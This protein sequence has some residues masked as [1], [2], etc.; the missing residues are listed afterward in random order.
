MN[1][2]DSF[3]KW[4]REKQGLSEK[5]AKDVLSRLNRVKKYIKLAKQLPSEEII[6]KMGQ[7]QEFKRLSMTVRSQLR[8]AIRLAKKFEKYK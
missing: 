6:F 4:L 7:N 2:G 5:S 8:R 3:K 1:S